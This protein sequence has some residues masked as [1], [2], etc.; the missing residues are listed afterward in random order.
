MVHSEGTTDWSWVAILTG[1]GAL[2]SAAGG[3]LLAIRAVRSKERKAAAS[4]IDSLSTMLSAE[5]HSRV[6]CEADRHQLRL[7]LT[8]H[9]I[10]LPQPKEVHDEPDGH[11]GEGFP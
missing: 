7:S 11:R 5:R 8:E 3:L 6:Q 10:D 9:G 2:I 1:V 4:E